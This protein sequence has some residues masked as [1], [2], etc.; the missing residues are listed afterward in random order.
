M[1]C[2]IICL[3]DAWLA[4]LISGRTLWRVKVEVLQTRKVSL[5]KS[6][7]PVVTKFAFLSVITTIVRKV[8]S[9]KFSAM[10]AS[11]LVVLPSTFRRLCKAKSCRLKPYS[12]H[13]GMFNLLKILES[14]KA[15]T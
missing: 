7:P 11:F 4:S 12:G 2:A 1:H 8:S 5:S 9:V 13:R 3:R 10:L 14:L 15:R 6:Q